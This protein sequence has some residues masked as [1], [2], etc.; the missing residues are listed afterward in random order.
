MRVLHVIDRIVLGLRLGQVD[1]EHEFRV[2]LARNQEET[3]RIAPNLVDQIAHRDVAAGALGEF[4]L[5]APLHHRH[6]LVQ[7]VRRVVPRNAGSR[8]RAERLQSGTHPRH[9]AV[10]IRSLHIDRVRESALP[11]GDV[12][13]DVRHEISVAAVGFPHH[14]ILVVAV[15]GGPEP[16]RAVLF[17]GLAR[18]SERAHRGLDLALGI[19]RGFEVII[20]EFHAERPEVLVL[21]AAQ[22]RDGEPAYRRDIA[23]IAPLGEIVGCDFAY[24]FAVVAGFGEGHRLAPLLACAR[25]H[26]KR[27][28]VDLHTG[29]VVIELARHLPA[30]CFEQGRDRVAQRGLAAVAHVQGAGGVCRNELDQDGPAPSG[31]GS[32]VARAGGM[33]RGQRIELGRRFKAQIDESRTGKFRLVQ[34]GRGGQPGDQRLSELARIAL[35]LARELHR[36]IARPVAV[37]RLLRTL[38]RDDGRRILRRHARQRLG[39][40][41][42]QVGL[43]CGGQEGGTCSEKG[44]VLYLGKF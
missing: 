26:G 16:Q 40:Q 25:L 37:R 29:I 11:L 32:A 30:L 13:G 5:L 41:I 6:H 4:Y 27:Q 43:D 1:V 10:M 34:P 14:P 18:G 22:R 21:L 42:G 36:D 8:H 7:H 3:H 44:C 23:R 19:E 31:F 24:V 12:V 2:G 38:Q 39:Q 33:H 35:Q 15:V 17:V 28:I 9:R 20:V